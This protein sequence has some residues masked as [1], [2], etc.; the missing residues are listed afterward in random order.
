[1]ETEGRRDLEESFLH[2]PV[3]WRPMDCSVRKVDRAQMRI[4]LPVIRIVFNL[5]LG[6]Y[7]QYQATDATH[8]VGC[9]ARFTMVVIDGVQVGKMS[10]VTGFFL[11]PTRDLLPPT[12]SDDKSSHDHLNSRRVDNL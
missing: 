2:S 6:Q 8:S 3:A 4:L 9:S 5:E 12:S 1:M 7:G 10:T 11:V